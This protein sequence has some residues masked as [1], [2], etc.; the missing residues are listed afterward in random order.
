MSSFKTGNIREAIIADFYLIDRLSKF[1]GYK[2]TTEEFALKRFESILKSNNDV[3]WVFEREKKIL[4]WIHVFT[5]YRVASS[6][7]AEIEGLIVDPDCRKEKIGRDLV[8]HAGVYAKKQELKIRVRTNIKRNETHKF[9]ESLGF[10]N[11]KSQYVF[12]LKP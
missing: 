11:V 7:F 3:V 2:K 8:R 6:S 1:L 4:G 9:Y 10:L 5:A 12:E